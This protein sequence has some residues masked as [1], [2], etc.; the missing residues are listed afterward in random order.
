VT[1]TREIVIAAGK[2]QGRWGKRQ[3]KTR[4]KA[5]KRLTTTTMEAEIEVECSLIQQI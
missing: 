3:G 1:N 2:S 5:G 4:G